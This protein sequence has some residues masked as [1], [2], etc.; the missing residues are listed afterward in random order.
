MAGQ[1]L[2]A[3]IGDKKEDSMIR[4]FLESGKK[5]DKFIGNWIKPKDNS[6]TAQVGRRKDTDFDIIAEDI[7]SKLEININDTVLDVCCGNG[8]ITRKIAN[9]SK[10]VYGLDFS[11]ILIRTA[12]ETNYNKNITYQLGD[13]LN[14]DKTTLRL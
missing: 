11:E 7:M 9:Y 14:V 1:K 4:N 8:L 10:E 12:K 13:A 3:R 5:T 6:L 2:S